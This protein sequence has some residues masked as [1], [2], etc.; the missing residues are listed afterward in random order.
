VQITVMVRSGTATSSLVDL[1]VYAPNGSKVGQIWFDNQAFSA[2]QTRSYTY[3]YTV[4]ATATLGTYAV[5]VGVFSPG[6][7]TLRSWNNGAAQFA[8]R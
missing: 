5:K 7:G 4:G 3:T 8:V 2:G 1:E 6:W